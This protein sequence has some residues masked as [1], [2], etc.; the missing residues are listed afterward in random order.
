MRKVKIKI[1]DDEK[2]REEIDKVYQTSSR[3]ILA[4]WA[5]NTAIRIMEKAGID[6]SCINE[7]QEGIRVNGLWQKG[8]ARIYDVRQ[9]ALRVNSLCKTAA[10]EIEKTVL[11]T[12]MH[13]IASGHMGEH[14]IVASDYA[15]KAIN[16]I[17]QNDPCAISREREAQLD[18]LQNLNCC[19]SF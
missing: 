11:R 14:S 3:Q 16:L 19:E 17:Y 4:K 10:T 6:Y 12:A 5:V 8:Q 18:D 15:V 9:I 13:A 7:V 1:K 2:L